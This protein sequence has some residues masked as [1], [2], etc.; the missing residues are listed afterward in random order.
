M[1]KVIKKHR[2]NNNEEQDINSDAYEEGHQKTPE[3]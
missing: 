3:E 1:K 2:R